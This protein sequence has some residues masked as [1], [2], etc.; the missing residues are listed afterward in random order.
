MH[1]LNPCTDQKGTSCMCMYQYYSIVFVPQ[2]LSTCRCGLSCRWAISK[3]AN[4]VSGRHT[5]R[6]IFA[7]IFADADVVILKQTLTYMSTRNQITLLKIIIIYSK[8]STTMICKW[9]LLEN[10]YINAIRIHFLVRLFM[11]PYL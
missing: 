7:R 2:D 3:F 5:R 4:I 6:R 10:E 8:S 11:R 9:K 1:V